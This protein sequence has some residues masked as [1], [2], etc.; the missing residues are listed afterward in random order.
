MNNQIKELIGVI[1]YSYFPYALGDTLTFVANLQSKAK[2][3]GCDKIRIICS[4]NK[5]NPSAQNQRHFI[6]EDNFHHFFTGLLPAI[7]CTERD[8]PLEIVQ[9]TRHLT[10]SYYRSFT[11]KNKMWPSLYSH[12]CRHIN[13]ATHKPM[14]D[15][16]KKYGD[17]VRLRA[18]IG[19]EDSCDSI[20][21]HTKAEGKIPVCIN[22]R[23]RKLTQN[24]SALHRDSNFSEWFN[25]LRE[26][27]SK[28][29]NYC[30]FL[31][32]AFHEWER[33]ILKLRNLIIPRIL[34]FG[35][36]EELALLQKSRLFMGTN[37]GFAN[38]AAFSYVPHVITSIEA[39]HAN[40]AEIKIGDTRHPFGARDQ[41]LL[42]EK[43]TKDNLMFN[44]E[45]VLSFQDMRRVT[46]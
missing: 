29:P 27:E 20:F 30:F 39:Q 13:Y 8:S 31:L 36:L 44:F 46:I 45:N 43:E 37:S 11:K 22:I 23:Q 2:L 19:H 15:C 16:F 18:P 5:Q 9:N 14:N 35:L 32:G 26:C 33:N 28:H 10:L 1:D 3:W 38:A 24:P 7:L 21:S 42:W 40:H 17:F 6:T 4:I 12:S 34:G 25:F 41:I